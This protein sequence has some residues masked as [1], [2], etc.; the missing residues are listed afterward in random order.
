MRDKNTIAIFFF[1]FLQISTFCNSVPL[2]TSSRWI[3]NQSTGERVK[4]VCANW[5][6]HLQPMIA[7]GLEKK[8]IN[9]IVNQIAVNGFN[10][11]RFTW[12]TFMF[13]RPDY[14][15][16]TV[17]QSLDKYNLTA[18]KSGIA[19]NNPGILNLKITEAHK[20]VVNELG[21]G[22]IMVVLDNH[23]SMPSWC[24]GSDDGNGFFGDPNFDP[25]EWLQGLAAVART[26]KGNSAV[27]GMSLRNE[28]RGNRQNEPDWYTYMQQGANTIHNENPDFLVIISGLSFA[29]NLGFLRTKPLE[30]N[31]NNKLVYEAHWYTFGT[32][33]DKWTAQT[34][35]FCASVIQTA[36][37]NYLFL[38]T[39]NYSFPLFLSEFGIDQRGGDEGQ[40]R[41]ITCLLAEVAGKDVDWAL[42]TFQGSYILREGT[43]NLEEVYGVMD[44]N[45]DRPRNPGYLDKLQLIR[46]INQESSPKNP[47]YYILFHPQSG[48]CVHTGKN[49][50]VFLDNCKKASRWDQH[51]DG[52]PMK[53]AGSPGCLVATANGGPTSVSNDCSSKMKFVSSSSFHLAV[54]NGDGSYLCLE[55]NGSDNAVVAKKCLCVG[56]DLVDLPTC[57]DNPQVQWFKLVPINSHAMAKKHFRHR[58]LSN[59]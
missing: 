14:Y 20:A 12:A 39:G 41:Y 45:W 2:S 15:S 29:T 56:D 17:S 18:A 44:I 42:W 36:R 58:L 38:T 51:Q 46:Q 3:I 54:E 19:E 43:V 50:N 27:V 23:V 8:P 47:T 57:A 31:L 35:T 1:I 52:G 49:N 22:N 7:E 37:N 5:V 53:L 13:T 16:L 21:K 6:A 40:N 48:Q 32:P 30:L 9:Y 4:L 33:V 11:V 59:Q 55:K 26:Y 25:N 10:C 28:L 24:C 34:N